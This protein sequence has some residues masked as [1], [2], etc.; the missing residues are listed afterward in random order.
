MTQAVAVGLNVYL[1]LH[2][3]E[4]F[5]I[6]TAFIMKQ[7]HHFQ[8]DDDVVVFFC[9]PSLRVAVPLCPGDLLIFNALEDNLISS[10]VSMDGQLYCIYLY[11]KSRVVGLNNNE[12]ALPP[13]EKYYVEQFVKY[14]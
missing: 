3:D 5:D 6:R 10:I 2:M 4:D 1:T 9:F 7:G 14:Y 13:K 12:T 8:P 11:L